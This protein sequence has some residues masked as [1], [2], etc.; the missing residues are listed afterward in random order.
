MHV[1]I[2]SADSVMQDFNVQGEQRMSKDNSQITKAK[3]VQEPEPRELDDL[4]T[5]DHDLPL[6]DEEFGVDL[7]DNSPYEN[8]SGA[9]GAAQP[10]HEQNHG[11][12]FTLITFCYLRRQWTACGHPGGPFRSPL[13]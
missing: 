5:Q 6:E 8:T 4:L 13:G 11:T 9:P 12:H 7:E 2:N 10:E 3:Q 1:D